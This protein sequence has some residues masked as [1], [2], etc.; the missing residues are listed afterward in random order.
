MVRD[1]LLF[2]S[3]SGAKI[4]KKHHI[5]LYILSKVWS[6]FNNAPLLTEINTSSLRKARTSIGASPQPPPEEGWTGE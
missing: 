3:L 4:Q 1:F 6:V 5:L 2:E